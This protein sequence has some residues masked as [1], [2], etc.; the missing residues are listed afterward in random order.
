MADIPLLLNTPEFIEAWE[1]WAQHRKEIRHSLT[2][3]TIVLQLRKLEKFGVDRAIKS[4]YNSIEGGYQGLFEPDWR[5][6]EQ[7]SCNLPEGRV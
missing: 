3:T 4:I 2:P 1:M 6:P 5:A 7:G